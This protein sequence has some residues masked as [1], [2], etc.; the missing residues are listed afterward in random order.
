MSKA[1][2]ATDRLQSVLSRQIA[3][4]EESCNCELF[5]RTGRGVVPTEVGAA[6]LPRVRALLAES[7]DI[8]LT[9]RS[10]AGVP[11][12]RVTVGLLPSI[13]IAPQLVTEI[14]ARFP[15]IQ[16]HLIQGS[17]G[18]LAEALAIGRVDLALLMRDPG[19]VGQT[20][21][22]IRAMPIYLVGGQGDPMTAGET[23][24]LQALDGLPLIMAGAPNAFRLHIEQTT[25]RNG[26]VPLFRTDADSLTMQMTLVKAGHG[27][28]VTTEMG[29]RGEVA[30]SMLQAARIVDPPVELPLVMA[31]TTQR[32]ATLAMRRVSELLRKL[33][34]EA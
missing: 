7:A 12:G 28:T 5:H 26:I 2:V 21:E 9:I 33:C 20:E 23:V 19:G 10:R 15:E 32:P 29:V 8:L 34:R 4:L 16:L 22:A 1:A 14:A 11:A 30:H 25:R 31:M 24:P 27:W 18:Q 6:L 17:T 3:A 13:N